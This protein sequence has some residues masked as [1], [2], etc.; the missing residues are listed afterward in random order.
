MALF[1][2]VSQNKTNVSITNTD[3]HNT[4]VRQKISSTVTVKNLLKNEKYCFA[5]GAYDFNE[6]LTNGE[7]GRTSEDVLCLNP[8]SIP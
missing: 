8:L 2:K 7:I 1:G 5:V 4:G 6:D 3:L